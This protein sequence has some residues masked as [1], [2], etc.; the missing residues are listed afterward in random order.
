MRSI[1]KKGF[2]ILK[3]NKRIH[4]FG[5]FDRFNYGDLLFPNLLE[6]AIKYRIPET[7]F[8]FYG[9]KR[10]DLRKFGGKKTR[11]IKELLLSNKAL[12]DNDII[13]IAGGDVLGIRF[14]FLHLCLLNN[15]FLKK[16][17]NKIYE[18]CDNKT[19][20]H[21]SKFCL[22]LLKMDFPF[23]ISKNIFS[24]AKVIYNTVGG[25]PKY[26][27]NSLAYK[28]LHEADY[29]SVRDNRTFFELKDSLPNI[30]IYPDSAVSISKYFP[31]DELNSLVPDKTKK[32]IDRLSK[33]Y[34]C[35]QFVLSSYNQAPDIIIN[36]INKL[37]AELN[38]PVM[39]LAIGRAYMHDDQV[40]LKQIAKG[41]KC[42][43]IL[44][45]DD[46]IYEIMFKIANSKI[47]IG[48]SLHGNITAL[49]YE[50]P[51]VGVNPNI[52]KL[53]SHL[54]TWESSTHEGC[55]T[56]NNIFTSAIQTLKVTPEELKVMKNH[57][58]DKI[59]YNFAMIVNSIN[60]N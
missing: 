28:Y 53:D 50:V 36:Q 34:I 57:L 16:A 10:A 37:A 15:I 12:N 22:G 23:I 46:T 59:D 43:Y 4:I 8:F 13:I 48:T 9:H 7:S 3:H 29:I 27:N 24:N 60:N 44:S 40:S 17:F 55:V 56:F 21:I 38:L 52:F 30:Q 33:G 54:K 26:E 39:L 41:L 14:T 31:R 49:S 47:F 18:I 35:V 6:K 32:M 1:G 42:P 51:H 20:S 5:A 11:S 58:V 45:C 25:I 19:S 2:E